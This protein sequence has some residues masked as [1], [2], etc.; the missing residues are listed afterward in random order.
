MHTGGPGWVIRVGGRQGCPA[1]KVRSTSNSDR[2]FQ[3]LACVAMGQE[4]T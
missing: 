3:G 4:L 2:K 1:V